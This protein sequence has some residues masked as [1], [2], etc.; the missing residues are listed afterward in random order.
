M[1]KDYQRYLALYAELKELGVDM[2]DVPGAENS[3]EDYD[4]WN[5]GGATIWDLFF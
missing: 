2:K 4:V 3:P 5:D 1:R